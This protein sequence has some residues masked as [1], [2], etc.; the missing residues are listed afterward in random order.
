MGKRRERGSKNVILQEISFLEWLLFVNFEKKVFMFDPETVIYNKLLNFLQMEN[1][2]L[3]NRSFND[4]S[5]KPVRA[6]A[7]RSSILRTRLQF[8]C[9]QFSNSVFHSRPA[10]DLPILAE[11]VHDHLF[12][13]LSTSWLLSLV[14]DKNANQKQRL[15]II[16][17]TKSFLK[18][19]S[20]V[21]FVDLYLLLNVQKIFTSTI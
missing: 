3:V 18:L 16:L 21:Y 1:W 7:V 13:P 9:K 12:R 17:I 4:D 14:Y 20:F 6:I 2:L 10:Y 15:K 11:S 19:E 5:G 8:I